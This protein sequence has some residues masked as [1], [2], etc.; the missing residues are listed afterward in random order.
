MTRGYIES[1]VAS[2]IPARL[3]PHRVVC[4]VLCNAC[5]VCPH[6]PP[7]R[8]NA[9]P[10]QDEPADGRAVPVTVRPY[11]GNASSRDRHHTDHTDH[12]RPIRTGNR[13]GET[14]T[15][16]SHA[17]TRRGP[18]RLTASHEPLREEG[19]RHGI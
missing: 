9:L 19:A 17:A 15:P 6:T 3:S 12:T 14:T 10:L 1:V 11:L 2:R 18:I 8:L 7:L 13:Q 16:E 5:V 4:V